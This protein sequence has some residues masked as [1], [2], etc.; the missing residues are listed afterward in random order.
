MS[1]LHTFI[2]KGL[3]DLKGVMVMHTFTCTDS[4]NRI[5]N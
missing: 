5:I 4:R 1:D 3:V 2:Y